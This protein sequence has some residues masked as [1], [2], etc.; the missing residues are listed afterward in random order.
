MMR[1]H[2]HNA[3]QPDQRSAFSLIEL[4]I[5]LA[6]LAAVAAITTPTLIS[7]MRNNQVFE[8]GETVREVLAESRK[9]AIDSGIDYEF[10][11]E[12][13]GQYFVVIP[14]EDE[15]SNAN[16]MQD[17]SSVANYVSVSGELPEN[18]QIRAME[19][20]AGESVESLPPETFGQLENALQLS[21]KTWSRPILFHFDGT[22]QDF[23]FRVSDDERRTVEISIRGL[24]G[25]IRLSQ[26]YQET[27]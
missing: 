21:Q 1:T 10:R 23:Q 8:A 2:T 6:L 12:P 26:V 16:S 13:G 4:L 7:E 9:Y 20:S 18:F 25:A 15:P 14:S 19:D 27:L 5:V 3:I 24:T 11:Y 17:D 22:A